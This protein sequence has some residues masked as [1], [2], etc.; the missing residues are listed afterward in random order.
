[1]GK[2]IGSLEAIVS[3]ERKAITEF[4]DT[5]VIYYSP[6]DRCWIAH[7]LRTDQVGT[8]ED[9]VQA[10]ADLVRGID[11]L[12]EL[13]DEDETVKFLREAPKD[14]QKMAAS[15]RPLPKEMYEIAHKLARGQWPQEIDPAFVARNDDETFTTELCESR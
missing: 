11:G 13:A 6:E 12:L 1:M 14:I 8:G 4:R 9:M 10:F 2:K 15:S 5:A 7:S 3:R